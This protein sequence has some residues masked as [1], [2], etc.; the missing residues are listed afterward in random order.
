VIAPPVTGVATL[1]E[2]EVIAQFV[3]L[4]VSQSVARQKIAE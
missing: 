2:V 1:R 4:L 3:P